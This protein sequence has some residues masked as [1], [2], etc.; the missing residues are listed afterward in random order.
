MK[1]VALWHC[2]G[3]GEKTRDRI[4]TYLKVSHGTLNKAE[5]IVEAAE[6]EPDIYGPI[7]ERVDKGQTSVDY[8]YQMVLRKELQKRANTPPLP[9]GQ[10]DV[11]YADPPWNYDVQLRGASAMQFLTMTDERAKYMSGLRRE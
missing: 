3:C 10:F 4:A 7:L 9:E 1:Q 6:R 5:V 8:R 11:I 2:L